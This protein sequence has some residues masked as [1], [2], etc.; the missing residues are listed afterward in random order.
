MAATPATG[1][2]PS[3]L[4]VLMSQDGSSVESAAVTDVVLEREQLRLVVIAVSATTLS[5]FHGS[6]LA[7]RLPLLVPLS[8]LVLQNVW[9]G[10]SQYSADPYLEGEYDDLRI[11]AGA[12]SDC[13]VGVLEQLGPSAP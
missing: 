3:G 4:A 5:V 8:A 10:R 11:Y 6:Q 12:L 9:L 1:F 2:V 13:A 7:A